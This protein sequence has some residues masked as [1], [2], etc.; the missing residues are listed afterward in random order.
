MNGRVNHAD[1]VRQALDDL[2]AGYVLR[3]LGLLDGA[4]KQTRGYM[5]R[6]PKHAERTP[7]CSVQDTSEGIL[8]KC[9]GECHWG[10]NALGLV[11]VRHGY[12]TKGSDFTKV[13]IEGARMANL[14]DVLDALRAER[15]PAR[16]LPAPM[17]RDVATPK[18]PVMPAE[19]F[20]ELVSLLLK[21]CPLHMQ[22][23]V[24]D[25]LRWRGVLAEALAAGWGAL[26]VLEEQWRVIGYPLE[27]FGLEA[28]ISSG[29]FWLRDGKPVLRDERPVFAWSEHR[30]LIP[31]RSPGGAIVNLQRR[32][33]NGGEP[34]KY[35]TPYG[36]GFEW[37]YGAEA[38][39]DLGEQTAVV[40]VEGA[41]D[42]LARRDK[43]R[44]AKADRVVLGVPGVAHWR[45]E[46][47]DYAK[48]RYAFVGLDADAAG[49]AKALEV[50]AD[51]QGKALKVT[52]I[53]PKTGKDWN[54]RHP[55]I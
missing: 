30:I 50:M 1:T 39:D 12:S 20:D 2:G 40:F 25:Y 16:E 55:T 53:K 19:P 41:I 44:E 33:P 5:I 32:C 36:R 37:P 17:P 3:A 31:Y 8:A 9:H 29:L 43:Y 46:W 24:C 11:A 7:S 47:A 13:L 52:R 14:Y 26:P 54:D 6:C 48:G 23:D 4:K 10:G 42:V 38:L 34:P 22:A 45:S 18:R 35:V 49:E 28:L 51:L 27:V 21:L 15:G